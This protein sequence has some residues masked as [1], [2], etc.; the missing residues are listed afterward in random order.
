MLSPKEA[1]EAVGLSKQSILRALRSG[2][3]SGTR[4]TNGEWEIDAAELFRVYQPVATSATLDEE[5]S[6]TVAPD[7]T[8]TLSAKVELLERL[9]RDRDETIDDLRSRLDQ[10]QA[11]V[12]Q[13][14]AIVANLA[15][16]PVQRRAN[17]WQRLL[18]RGE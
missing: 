7:Q 12:A 14:T 13:L 17:W 18:G 10:S 5:L 11:Q 15:P 3:L 16:S 1:G 9:L 6:T 2:K 8:A 4:N